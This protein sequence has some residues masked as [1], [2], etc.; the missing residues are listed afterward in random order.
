MDNE[1]EVLTSN[2]CAETNHHMYNNIIID[3]MN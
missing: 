3:P 1:K 2:K